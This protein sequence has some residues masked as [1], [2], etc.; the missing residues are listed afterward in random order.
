[1]IAHRGIT[2]HFAELRQQVGERPAFK[3]NLW[4]YPQRFLPTPIEPEKAV[5][6]KATRRHLMRDDEITVSLLDLEGKP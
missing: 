1:M 3:V 5:N 6:A 2:T 4:A